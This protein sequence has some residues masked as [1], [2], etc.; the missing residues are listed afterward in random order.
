MANEGDAIDEDFF[1]EASRVADI[2]DPD[3]LGRNIVPELEPFVTE[4]LLG[5]LKFPNVMGYIEETNTQEKI[6][7]F[8]ARSFSILEAFAGKMVYDSGELFGRVLEVQHSSIFNSQSEED[9]PQED[10]FDDRSDDKGPEPDGVAIY[11]SDG[12]EYAFITTQRTSVI[13]VVDVT[14]RTDVEFVTTARNFR[15]AVRD[16]TDWQCGP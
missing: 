8:G 15:V 10:Q 3:E 6:F 7:A 1:S 11:H 12:R 9:L 14:D 2:T 5:R 4:E 13:F 16:R